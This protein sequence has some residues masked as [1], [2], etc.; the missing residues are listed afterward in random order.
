MFLCPCFTSNKFRYL[1]KSKCNNHKL[2]APYHPS[3]NAQVELYEQKV[4]KNL[5]TTVN[6]SGN[7][8]TKLRIFLI[9]SRKVINMSTGRSPA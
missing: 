8:H 5:R 2:S 9:K 4:N 1:L 6:E 3:I 7:P